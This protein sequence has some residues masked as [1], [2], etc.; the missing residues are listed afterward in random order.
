MSVPFNQCFREADLT[1]RHSRHVLVDPSAI[2]LAVQ[3][4]SPFSLLS[5]LP[6][7]DAYPGLSP[8][9]LL[10]VVGIFFAAEDKKE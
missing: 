5:G 6:L 8:Y 3:I 10:T 9:P 7:W 1:T 4:F 2:P